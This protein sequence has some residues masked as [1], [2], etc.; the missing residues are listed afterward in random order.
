MTPRWPVVRA[1]LR[2]VR[3]RV[4]QGGSTQSTD[5]SDSVAGGNQ[6]NAPV[7]APVTVGGNAVAVLDDAVVAG[8][9]GS[10]PAGPAEGGPAEG[11]STQ[12]TDGSDSIAGGN[13]VNTPVTAPVTVGDNAVG[14]IGEGTVEGPGTPGAP[15]GAP[16][17]PA[18]TFDE[19]AEP[20]DDAAGTDGSAG[21]AMGDSS[22]DGGAFE[23]DSTG[24][25]LSRTTVAA[26]SAIPSL[27]R[28]GFSPQLVTLGFLALVA[29]LALVM[30]GRRRFSAVVAR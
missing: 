12:S 6:V 18:D 27:A 2:L 28:T 29:G 7:T 13:Q 4:V 17:M 1:R 24:V 23:D 21:P 15:G 19:P 10:A 22:G 16:D 25:S 9:S 14:V 20:G 5:G 3:L 8:G 30:V 11:G 26:A